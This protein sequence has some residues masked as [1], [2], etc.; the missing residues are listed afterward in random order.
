MMKADDATEKA[1][2]SVL[3][4]F[5]ESY[6]KR[7]LNS[8][9]SLIA[10]DADVVMY[11][12]GAD[13]KR[14]GPK[15]IKAQFERDLS[16]IEDPALE[17]KWTSISAS[18]NVAWIAIDAVF[19]AKVD[20]KNMRFPSRI[21]EVLEKRGDTWLIVQGHFSFPDQSQFFD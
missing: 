7:D 5:A 13:E 20:G 1:V 11:G 18:G 2:K 17:Y 14:I 21:T 8:A 16:Q 6:A 4:K 10:P 19:K 3:E 12:T 9:M 15:E